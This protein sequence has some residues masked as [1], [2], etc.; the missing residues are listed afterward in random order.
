[1]LSRVQL[2]TGGVSLPL[3]AHFSRSIRDWKRVLCV[4]ASSVL[5]A[6]VVVQNVARSKETGEKD[7]GG[8]GRLPETSRT[9]KRALREI[10]GRSL[11]FH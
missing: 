8:D 4:L 10:G 1:M 11:H 6:S 7:P 5:R 3:F 9:K 2:E